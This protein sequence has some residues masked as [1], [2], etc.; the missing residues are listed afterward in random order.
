MSIHIFIMT[1]LTLLSGFIGL[2]V[3]FWGFKNN[4]VKNIIKGSIVF[5][6]AI[7]LFTMMSFK[8]SRV[9]INHYKQ[10]V[11]SIGVMMD[12]KN[13]NSPCMMKREFNKKCCPGK[14]GS[15]EMTDTIITC[16]K[17]IEKKK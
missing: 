2:V 6:I 7:I 4:H 5:C 10:K 15:M 16:K 1:L 11:H 9:L 13:S 12:A 17:I 3:L 14:D 8:V